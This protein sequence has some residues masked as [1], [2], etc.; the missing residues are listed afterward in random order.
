MSGY[1]VCAVA[2][3]VGGLLPALYLTATGRPVDRLIGVE[4]TSSVVTVAMLLVSD[5]TAES[6]ELIVPIVLVALSLAGA[7]VFTRLIGGVQDG[8]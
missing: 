5:I 2:L 3:M 6:Y 1:E 4:L 7:L 8:P